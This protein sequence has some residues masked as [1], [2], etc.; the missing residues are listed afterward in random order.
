ML[1]SL[2]LVSADKSLVELYRD[3]TRFGGE[4]SFFSFSFSSAFVLARVE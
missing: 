4:G 2:D 1:L 3:E